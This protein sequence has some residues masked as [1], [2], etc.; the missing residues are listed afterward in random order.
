MS[1]ASS[2]D[3][4]MPLFGMA[5]CLLAARQGR[6]ILAR[7]R[8]PVVACQIAPLPSRRAVLTQ[9]EIRR[10]CDDTLDATVR[11]GDVER[12]TVNH[13]NHSMSLRLS[14]SPLSL[15]SHQSPADLITTVYLQLAQDTAHVRTDRLNSE[16]QPFGDLRVGQAGSHQRRDLLLTWGQ[17]P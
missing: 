11:Q 4:T 15:P 9:S 5:D 7:L 14:F 6:A 2:A 1:A 13:L 16:I 12:V 3:H 10:G 8:L 17:L